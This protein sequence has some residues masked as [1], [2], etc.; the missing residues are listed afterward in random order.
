MP[1]RNFSFIAAVLALLLGSSWVTGCGLQQRGKGQ[2]ANQKSNSSSQ[3]ID[4]FNGVS[5]Y[6]N[7]IDEHPK[8]ARIYNDMCA[9]KFDLRDYH[10]AIVDYG[11]AI[12]IN[13]RNNYVFGNRCNSKIE[14][15]D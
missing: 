11:K 5:L 4:D 7:S 3:D 1:I 9:A 2:L 14:L 12:E 13:P 8:D 15:E 6:G 10:G